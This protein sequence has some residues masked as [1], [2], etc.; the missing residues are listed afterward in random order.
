MWPENS[1]HRAAVPV[2]KATF[3]TGTPKSLFFS[4]GHYALSTSVQK[5]DEMLSRFNVDNLQTNG[6]KIVYLS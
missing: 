4:G 6:V 1:Q 3:L 5:H 2:V